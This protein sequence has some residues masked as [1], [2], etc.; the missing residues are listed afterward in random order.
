[1]GSATLLLTNIQ[2]TKIKDPKESDPVELDS[3][4]ID[5]ASI[6]SDNL[7]GHGPLG[8]EYSGEFEKTTSKEESFEK[9]FDQ[10]IE[11][12]LTIGGEAASVKNELKVT[13]GFSQ[14]TTDTSGEEERQSRTFSF[15]GDTE[16]GIRERI[17]AWRKVTKMRSVITGEGDYE[18]S[19]QMGKHWHGKWLGR[20][21]AVLRDLRR[22]H[23]H[24]QGRGPNE[25]ASR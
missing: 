13:L 11:N 25:L 24:H 3:K 19:I 16:E 6:N 1:M 5:A 21:Q 14:S 20:P 18:H 7:G 8:W 12:T 17:T 4:I 2:P 10:S 23:P 22:L 15:H 9:G